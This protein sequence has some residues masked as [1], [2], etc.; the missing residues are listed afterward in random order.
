M[1]R[2]LTYILFL[3]SGYLV[4][5]GVGQEATEGQGV[6]VALVLGGSIYL[7]TKV[8]RYIKSRRG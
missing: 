8:Y 7:G 6:L 5:L 1:E 3:L 2:D 4:G